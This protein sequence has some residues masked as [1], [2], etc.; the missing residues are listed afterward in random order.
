MEHTSQKI[1]YLGNLR[2]GQYF[3]PVYDC[4]VSP[5]LMYKRLYSK[6]HT[7]TVWEPGTDSIILLP[8]VLPVRRVIETE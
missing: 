6:C 3:R 1:I 2:N 8:A 7:V 5:L 4:E